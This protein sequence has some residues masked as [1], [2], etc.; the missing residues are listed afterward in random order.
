MIIDRIELLDALELARLRLKI[1][2]SL[3]TKAAEDAKKAAGDAAGKALFWWKVAAGEF[4]VI[5][6]LIMALIGKG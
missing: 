2:N 5:I 4:L 3:A 6:V 1:Q